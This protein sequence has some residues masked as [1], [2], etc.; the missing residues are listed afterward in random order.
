MHAVASATAYIMRIQLDVIQK[1]QHIMYLRF[2][3][4]YRTQRASHETEYKLNGE[5]ICI[6]SGQDSRQHS[7]IC[8]DATRAFN[9]LGRFALYDGPRGAE[10]MVAYC[11][12]IYSTLRVGFLA[13]K[14]IRKKERI[15]C[16][17]V[18]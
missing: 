17:N 16:T 8:V 6:T 7:P 2:L 5:N 1:L 13:A 11:A 12:Y 15:V 9:L 18:R 14:T 4:C 3:S 10:N